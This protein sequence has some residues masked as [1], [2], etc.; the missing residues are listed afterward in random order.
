MLKCG[1]QAGIVVIYVLRIENISY[2]MTTVLNNLC[3]SNFK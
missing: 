2:F 3:F 1:V